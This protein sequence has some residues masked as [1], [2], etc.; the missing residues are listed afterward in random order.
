MAK[1]RKK[2]RIKN[3]PLNKGHRVIIQEPED[4][5]SKPPVFS[6]EKVQQ[7]VEKYGFPSLDKEKKAFFS[8]AIYKRSK[9][10]WSELKSAPRHGLGF[11]KISKT[12]IKAPI[13]CFITDEVKY[14]L[15]FR[16]TGK[17]PMVGYR[18]K[19]IFYVLWFDSD[20]TLYDH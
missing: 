12:S 3:A 5:D 1:G 4:Y 17:N 19:N 14:F 15:A 2:S 10:S 16:F 20:F 13:P 18:I 8:D 7:Q 9:L 11:E 6:L